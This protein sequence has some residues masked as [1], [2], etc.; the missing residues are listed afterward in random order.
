M[1]I[2]I[3][4]ILG[5]A[6]ESLTG[7]KDSIGDFVQSEDFKKIMPYLVSGGGGAL[8]GALMTGGRR[9]QKG[10]GRLGHLGRV[11]GNALLAGG[12]AAGAHKLINY[13]IDQTTGGAEAV[14]DSSTRSS[15]VENVISNTAF[16]PV[17]AGLFG[18]GALLA[19]K[20]RDLLGSGMG[21][22]TQVDGYNALWRQLKEQMGSEKM[23]LKDGSTIGSA[24]ELSKL[25]RTQLNELLDSKK[26]G[27]GSGSALSAKDYLS[28]IEGNKG[29]HATAR[30]HGIA[31]GSWKSTPKAQLNRIFGKTVGKRSVRGGV[32]LAAALLP[33]LA[34]SFM[35]SEEK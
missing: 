26:G 6:G 33:A 1:P 16:S 29:L 35:T 11:L 25:N 20:N 12:T 7:A 9:E 10:E 21:K 18:G 3:N 23:P 24:E 2:D 28:S 14:Q 17:T 27:R 5:K 32:G 30:D 22:Q 31:S 34:G 4:S 13:G 19:T 15:P 8:M